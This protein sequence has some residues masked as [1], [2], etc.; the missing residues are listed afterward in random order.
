MLQITLAAVDESL[1][2]AWERFCGDLTFVHVHHGTIFDVHA[3]AYISPANSFGFMDGG[4]DM[5]YSQRFGWEVQKNLQQIIRQKHHGELLI[6]AAEIIETNA[7]NP[8]FIIA[9]PTMRVPM[10]LHETVNPYLAARAVF[11][12]IEHGN[13]SEP[14][15]LAGEKISSAVQSVVFPGLGT[16]IGGVGPNTCAKQVRAA[17]DEFLI[18]RH[19]FPTTWADASLRHQL[20]YTDRP[21]NLHRDY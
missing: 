14:N 13:F 3:D 17:I 18:D 15:T 4:L 10:I 20:L 11:L 5:M 9:A 16:G 8:H 7:R 21:R 2:E 19:T 12:L 6:G 1:A